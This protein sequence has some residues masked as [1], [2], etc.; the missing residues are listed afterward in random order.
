MRQS[1]RGSPRPDWHGRG[2]K[3]TLKL[4]QKPRPAQ[5]GYG[6]RGPWRNKP[7]QD[8]LAQSMSGLPWLN[9]N[10]D[11]PPLPFALSV[12]DMYAGVHLVQGILACLL[13]RSIA[14]KG[15]LVEVSLME[16]ILDMQFEALTVYL[17][18]NGKLPQRSALSSAHPYVAAPYGISATADGYLALAMGSVP[19]LGELLGCPELGRFT[20]PQSWFAKRDEIKTILAGRLQSRPT[21]DWLG[22]LEPAGV[23]CADVFTWQDLMK[24]EGF[25]ALD[26]IQEVEGNGVRFRTTRCPIRIDGEI[27]KDTAGAPGIGENTPNLCR[28]FKP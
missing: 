3:L 6:T 20:D 5:S 8:L 9:G 14:K 23:W 28:E 16:S 22:I 7:G 4:V 17:N 27:L 26:M 25:K 24:Q 11:Q 1:G 13:R 10:A 15:G 12:A 2:R 21:A 18:D 19:R